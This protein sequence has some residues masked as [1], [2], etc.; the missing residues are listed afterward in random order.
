MDENK[1]SKQRKSVPSTATTLFESIINKPRDG[2]A[3]PS[4]SN[5]HSPS[6]FGVSKPKDSQDAKFATKANPFQATESGLLFGTPIINNANIPAGSV[7]STHKIGSTPATNTGNIFSYL[8]ESSPNSSGNENDDDDRETDDEQEQ[9]SEDQDRSAAV[10][11]DT[12]TPPIQNGTSLFGAS[13]LGSSSNIFGGLSKPTEQSTKGGL[14]GRVQMGANGQPVRASP[15]PDEKQDSS[16]SQPLISNETPAKRPGDYTFNPATTPISFGKPA[17]DISKPSATAEVIPNTKSNAS[18]P[19]KP[20]SI[21]GVSSQGTS[22]PVPNTPSLFGSLS[23][24]KPRSSEAPVSMFAPQKPAS[25]PS[26]F[27][28]PSTAAANSL[29][30]REQQTGEAA[31]VTEKQTVNIF[32]KPA[33]SVSNTSETKAP[34]S[35]DDSK[36]VPNVPATESKVPSIFDKAFIANNAAQAKTL[37]NS[38]KPSPDLFSRNSN[39]LFGGVKE[40]KADSSTPGTKDQTK[41]QPPSIFDKAFIATNAAQAKK[42]PDSPQPSPDLFSRGSN[43]LFGTAGVAKTNGTT[44]A[45]TKS[46]FSQTEK[47]VSSTTTSSNGMLQAPKDDKKETPGSIFGQQGGSKPAAPTSSLFGQKKPEEPAKPTSSIFGTTSSATGSMFN[48]GSQSSSNIAQSPSMTFG[49]SATSSPA[50][51]FGAPNSQANGGGSEKAGFQFGSTGPSTGS[52]SFTF[53]QDS[54]AGSGFTFTAGADKQSINNPFAAPQPSSQPPVPIFGGN[55]SITTPS[56]SFNL[57][58]GQP[59]STP[60]AVPSSQGGA[61]FGGPAITNGAPSFSFSQASPSQNSLDVKF[62]KSSAVNPFGH[63][64]ASEGS[65]IASKSLLRC[66]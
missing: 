58:F 17:L 2:G 65:I 62:P 57:S 35:N 15:G 36:T 11:T 14:F 6:L 33:T 63:L 20:I 12:S 40:P 23:T 16:V 52:A 19:K 9:D 21:F 1:P 47:P 42:L 56:S 24:T 28:T 46:I 5:S 59:S 10:S 32:D 45:D 26:I 8:S 13:K 39:P 50:V 38:S 37:S 44:S 43:P 27:G 64:Q 66:R 22:G 41:D 31:S 34:T 4:K 29:F 25:T 60:K 3:S 18:E 7:L 53:G 54:S 30:G 51:S 49:A 48:F 61:L 55:S